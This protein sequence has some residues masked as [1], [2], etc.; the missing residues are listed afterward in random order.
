MELFLK[1]NLFVVFVIY[2]LEFV[3]VLEF[4]FGKWVGIEKFFVGLYG[5]LFRMFVIEKFL[6]LID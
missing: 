2:F 1:F 4:I 6:C 5:F 3:V